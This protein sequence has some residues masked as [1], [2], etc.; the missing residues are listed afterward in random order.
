MIGRAVERERNVSSRAFLQ[1]K[2]L[3]RP[4]QTAIMNN[5]QYRA[6]QDF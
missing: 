3:T 4:G 2:G 5:V 1:A 6:V